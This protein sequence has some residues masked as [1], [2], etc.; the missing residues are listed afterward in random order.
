MR[1]HLG[2]EDIEPN[3]WVAWVFEYPGCYSRGTTVQ[4]TLDGVE[5]CVNRHVRRLQS[6]QANTETEITEDVPV[7]YEIAERHQSFSI[8]GDDYYV[9]ACFR[10]DRRPLTEVEIADGL[11]LMRLYRAEL[12]GLVRPLMTERLDQPIPGDRFGTI[13]GILQHVAT[14]EWWYL[15]RLDRAFDRSLLATDIFAL[16]SQVREH[17]AAVLSTLAG[18][19]MVAEKRGERWTARKVV[20]RALWH[21][22]VHTRQIGRYLTFGNTIA[23]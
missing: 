7:E 6:F 23:F 21:E 18:S 11:L 14:A 2:I 5:E 1:V 3:N 4:E 16:L 12:L 10:D 17:T 22:Q 15:D 20:R 9:N 13:R 8:A 19:T